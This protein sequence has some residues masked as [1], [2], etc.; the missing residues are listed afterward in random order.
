MIKKINIGG[1]ERGF[2]FGLGF[3]GELLE[4]TDL[5]IEEIGEKMQKNPFKWIPTIMYHSVKYHDESKDIPLVYTKADV[6]DWIDEIGI[7]SE[8]VTLFMKSFIES[9]T[10]GVPN[11]EPVKEGSAK[12]K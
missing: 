12:K 1:E 11:E 10:K 9:L 3:L 2:S 7:A 6:V 4:D 8:Q 5:T